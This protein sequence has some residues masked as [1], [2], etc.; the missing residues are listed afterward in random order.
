MLGGKVVKSVKSRIDAITDA[1]IQRKLSFEWKNIY[2][3]LMSLSN[4]NSKF[5]VNAFN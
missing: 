1:Y 2:R 4:S 5:S 3:K